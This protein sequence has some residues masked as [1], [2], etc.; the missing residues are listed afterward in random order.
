MKIP[1]STA[2]SGQRALAEIEKTLMSF[3]CTR[4]GTMVDQSRGCVI[5]QLTYKGKDVSIEASFKGYAAALL[6]SWSSGRRGT[7]AAL[8]AKALA[9]ARISV[10]SILRDWIKGQITAIE[11]GV[12][13]FEGAFL[14]QLLLGS[15]QTVLSF[16]RN[17]AKLLP[18]PE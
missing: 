13:E 2:T 5:V 4:F 16:M 9:Q 12:L 1:Y 7:R 10:C 11:V 18:S 17:D 3:G 6:R 15:G 14:G 8:E